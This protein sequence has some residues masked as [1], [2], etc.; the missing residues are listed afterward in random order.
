MSSGL[1][2]PA[3]IIVSGR[4]LFIK[5]IELKISSGL[6]ILREDARIHEGPPAGLGSE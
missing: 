3:H 1:F 5:N 6:N 4:Q 2:V